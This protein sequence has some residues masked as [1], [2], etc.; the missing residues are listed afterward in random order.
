MS[1]PREIIHPM[2][3]QIE[4]RVPTFFVP[5]SL[6]AACSKSLCYQYDG[7]D[8]EFTMV[9][10]GVTD[11]PFANIGLFLGL[12]KEAMPLSLL[13]NLVSNFLLP[14]KILSTCLEID[15]GFY[16]LLGGVWMYSPYDYDHSMFSM[17][18][19]SISALWLVYYL[20]SC[21]LCT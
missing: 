5:T 21:W 16:Q 8:I 1:Y 10:F 9:Y 11:E 18:L 4:W 17:V 15:K 19:L 3:L 14:S 6:I 13:T 2:E 20:L 12:T 7:N